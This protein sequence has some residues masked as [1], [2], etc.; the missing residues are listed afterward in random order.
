MTI[1]HFRPRPKVGDQELIEDSQ[2]TVNEKPD[3]L[4]L[5]NDSVLI[6]ATLSAPAYAYLIALHPNGE[7]QRYYP[8]SDDTPPPYTSEIVSPAQTDDVDHQFTRPLTDGTGLQAFVLVASDRPL[9]TY[10]AWIKT[11]KP[12]LPWQP[13][14]ADAEGVWLFDGSGSIKRK[15]LPPQPTRSEARKS[16]TTAPPTFA[17]T[18][19]VL[20][21]RPEVKA[22]QAWAFPVLPAG[23]QYRL[24]PV[25]PP[26]A[27]GHAAVVEDV[28]ASRLTVVRGDVEYNLRPVLPLRT[29]DR[30]QIACD[31]PCGLEPAVY[32]VDS[33]GRL[34]RLEALRIEHGDDTDR[35]GY[36]KGAND[37][38][39][40]DWKTRPGRS[41]S[42]S[43]PARKIRSRPQSS[44]HFWT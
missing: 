21:R 15:D 16:R 23:A 29:G 25:A 19:K 20:A 5:E 1:E 10:C 27:S 8:D 42:W 44:K 30:L 3:R 40:L 37:R 14:E 9:P 4:I 33:T 43:V 7:F 6:H 28:A 26:H 2:G 18:C 13:S 34:S 24:L 35:V 38:V 11:V 39:P 12:S 17:E 22:I 41:S 31:V 36:H 32:W